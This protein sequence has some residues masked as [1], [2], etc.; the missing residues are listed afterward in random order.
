[1]LHH[2]ATSGFRGREWSMC[3][4]VHVVGVS[5]DEEQQDPWSCL[6]RWAVVLQVESAPL[7]RSPHHPQVTHK[8]SVRHIYRKLCVMAVFP[9][10]SF[11]DHKA[12][13]KACVGDGA[14]PKGEE[15]FVRA[16]LVLE[17]WGHPDRGSGKSHPNRLHIQLP[18]F[19]WQYFL[20]SLDS[21]RGVS[22]G[23]SR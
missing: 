15:R 21:P 11:L 12:W 5:C 19:R 14:A 3:A 10:V 16:D 9:T 18:W 20:E 4:C 1:M 2:G 13:R 17:G 8:C 23:A 22:G 6:Q 7:C